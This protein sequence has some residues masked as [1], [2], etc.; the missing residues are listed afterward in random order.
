MLSCVVLINMTVLQN[1]QLNN[2]K[3]AQN[4]RI[5]LFITTYIKVLNKIGTPNKTNLN[6]LRIPHKKA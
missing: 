2:K 6:G 5:L 4:F 3:C 1:T